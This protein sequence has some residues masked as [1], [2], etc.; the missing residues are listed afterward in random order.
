M[1]C[2][3]PFEIQNKIFYYLEH[4]LT[5]MFKN[6]IGIYENDEYKRLFCKDTDEHICCSYF[7][8]NKLISSLIEDDIRINNIGKLSRSKL[9]S[10]M[11]LKKV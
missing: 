6:E 7:S 2:D 5:T 10:V 1:I 4:P 9:L 3:L 8:G 11:S